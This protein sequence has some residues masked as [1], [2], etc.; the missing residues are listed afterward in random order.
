LAGLTG[1]RVLPSATNFL[2]VQGV[3]PDGSPRSLEPLR[4]ALE[5]RQRVLLRDCRSFEGLGECWLRIGLQDRAGN[6]RLLRALA[7][8]TAQG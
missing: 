7:I 1:L 6:R 2:L 3:H 8:E 4:G 5:C